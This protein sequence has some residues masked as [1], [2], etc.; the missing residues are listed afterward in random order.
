[1]RLT[2]HCLFY[3]I[4][5][6]KASSF[7]DWTRSCIVQVVSHLSVTVIAHEI[8]CYFIFF[9]PYDY[10]SIVFIPTHR[11]MN[12]YHGHRT[13]STS[14]FCSCKTIMAIPNLEYL[15]VCQLGLCWRVCSTCSHTHCQASDNFTHTVYDTLPLLL[16]TCLS[17]WGFKSSPNLL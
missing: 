7:P 14:Q 16:G 17:R 8:H 1:M 12:L 13:S 5:L 2:L 6:W 10:T 9:A 3:F 15:P 11:R 4:H